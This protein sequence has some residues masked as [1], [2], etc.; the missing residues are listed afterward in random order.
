MSRPVAILGDL[1][2]AV[3]LVLMIPFVIII[4]GLPIVLVVR[5][6]MALAAW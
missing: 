6:G 3:G 2:S 4:I 1:V 5:L